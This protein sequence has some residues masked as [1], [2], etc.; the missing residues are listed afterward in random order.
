MKIKNNYLAYLILLISFILLLIIGII[1]HFYIGNSFI[2][3]LLTSFPFT[4][5]LYFSYFYLY[6]NIEDNKKKVLVMLLTVIRFLVF[7]LMI[8]FPFLLIHFTKESEEILNYLYLIMVPL[9]FTLTF[10]LVII[11]KDKE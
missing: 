6:K 4:F 7:I 10:I 9:E 11:F 5:F 2:Y 3:T 8:L 1:L